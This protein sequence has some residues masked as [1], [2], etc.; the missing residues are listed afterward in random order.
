MIKKILFLLFISSIVI[1]QEFNATVN[2]NYT[3]I[4]TSVDRTVFENL[5]K[6]IIN[7]FNQNWTN[8]SFSS[9]ERIDC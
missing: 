5:K 7:F 1:G 8:E 2:I 6:N 3:Q 4:N 9:E